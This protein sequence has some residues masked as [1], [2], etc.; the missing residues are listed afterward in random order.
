MNINDV[1]IGEVVMS[2]DTGNVTIIV[3]DRFTG[4]KTE[5]FLVV[6]EFNELMNPTGDCYQNGMKVICEQITSKK[7]GI[8][9]NGIELEK[10]EILS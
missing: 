9:H 1:K 4:K 8:F 5:R 3:T 2:A 6:S 7:S 10:H